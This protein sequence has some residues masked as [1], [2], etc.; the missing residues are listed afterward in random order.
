MV[1]LALECV[2]VADH[3]KLIEPG[4]LCDLTGQV[5]AALVVQIR[6]RL[7]EKGYANL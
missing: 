6:S 5:F 2:I 1:S 7:V 4:D 3:E